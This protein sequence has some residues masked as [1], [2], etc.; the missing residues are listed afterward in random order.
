[1]ADNITPV[2]DSEG[3]LVKEVIS[4]NTPIEGTAIKSTNQDSGMVLTS[5]GENGASWQESSGGVTDHAELTN[6]T[7]DQHHS[8]DHASR[9]SEDGADEIF[10]ENLGTG[11][12]V[13]NEIAVSD[14]TGG[15]TMGLRYATSF[16]TVFR[17]AGVAFPNN[18]SGFCH[19]GG[20]GAITSTEAFAQLKAI[21]SKI[22]SIEGYCSN[23]SGTFTLR[24]NGTD[25]A[26]TGTVNS[27][28]R[29]D[30]TGE[31]DFADGDL[32]SLAYTSG[33]NFTIYGIQLKLKSEVV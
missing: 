6:V 20:G 10:I 1:M 26:L 7:K 4:E 19:L 2:L 33:V 12:V 3:K 32:I 11:S 31:I 27:V 18:D 22:V 15:L 21:N 13:L 28:G 16:I 24:K 29:F 25:T 14:G 9:H 8:E 5:D 23:G 17:T 30:I